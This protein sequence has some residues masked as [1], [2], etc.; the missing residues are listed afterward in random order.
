M[1]EHI[2]VCTKCSTT[3]AIGLRLHF[4]PYCGTAQLEKKLL[5]TKTTQNYDPSNPQHKPWRDNP[6][7]PKRNYTYNDSKKKKPWLPLMRQP[8]PK[9]VVKKTKQSLQEQDGDSKI[10]TES[11]V[12]IQEHTSEA[13]NSLNGEVDG[14]IEQDS[15]D[16]N[17]MAEVIVEPF[18]D[19]KYCFVL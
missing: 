14:T 11:K 4:C 6:R 19:C 16:E 13:F 18:T 12:I 17:K 15:E 8:N 3:L 7:L 9:K 5:H 10:A 1:N 2:Q